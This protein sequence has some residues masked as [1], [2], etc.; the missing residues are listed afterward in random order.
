MRHITAVLFLGWMTASSALSGWSCG[1][2]HLDPMVYCQLYGWQELE[3]GAWNF[4]LLGDA[5]KSSGESAQA[6]IEHEAVLWGLDQLQ[7][8]MSRLPTGSTI[9]WQMSVAIDLP[10]GS[11]M[12]AYLEPP[13]APILEEISRFAERYHIKFFGP[14]R[15]CKGAVRGSP[16]GA[17]QRP[18]STARDL[19]SWR[20]S[21][22]EWSFRVLPGDLRTTRSVKELFSDSKAWRGLDRLQKELSKLPSGSRVTWRLDL[23]LELP[24]GSRVRACVDPP[25][26]SALDEVR[27]LA[28]AHQIE[29]AGPYS[30]CCSGP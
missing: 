3:E 19:Y 2:F 12:G 5:W 24:S 8:Q 18:Q 9:V 20:H 7:R 23:V 6:V 28:N 13:P 26:V 1:D 16:P 4:L 29:V 27:H 10:D 25:P 15:S 21:R 14:L 22:D 11:V 17:P 30:P